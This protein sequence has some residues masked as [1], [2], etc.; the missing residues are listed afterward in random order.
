MIVNDTQD[1]FVR[2]AKIICEIEE[3]RGKLSVDRQRWIIYLWFS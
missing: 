3:R 2:F 1:T